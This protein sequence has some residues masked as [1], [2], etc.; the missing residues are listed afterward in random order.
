MEKMGPVTSTPCNVADV[1]MTVLHDQQARPS[2]RLCDLLQ[3]PTD[4]CCDRSLIIKRLLFAGFDQ[5]A[6]EQVQAMFQKAAQRLLDN[7]EG[8]EPECAVAAYWVP[9]RIEIAGKHTDYAGGRSLLAAVN[10]GFAVVAAQRDDNRVG[11]HAQF[12]DGRQDQRELKLTADLAQLRQFQSLPTNEGGWAAYPAAV[13]QRLVANFSICTG[14]HIS[15]ECNLPEASG[16]SSSS[17]VICYMWLV[18]DKYNGI[19]KGN[20]LFT[21][22]IRSSAELYTYLGNIENGKHFKP[23]DAAQLDGAG[24]VGTFGG[25]EDHTAIMSCSQGAVSLWKFCPT[26]H[27]AT[28][29]FDPAVSFCIAVSGAKAEKRGEAMVGYNDASLL[30]QWAAAAVTLARAASNGVALEQPLTHEVLARIYNRTSLYNP[31]LPNLAEVVRQERAELGEADASEVKASIRRR[32]DSIAGTFKQHFAVNAESLGLNLDGLDSERITMDLLRERFE[33]FFNESEVMLPEMVAA[34]VA[35]DYASFGRLA[36]R[37]HEATVLQLQNTVPETAWLARWARR[38]FIGGA[39][40]AAASAEPGPEA[41]AAS[42]FGAGFGGSCWAL[43]WSAEAEAF[44]HAWKVAYEAEFPERCGGLRRDF[45]VATPSPG[46]F[47][48]LEA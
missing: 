4:K 36:D 13:V 44:C 21:R 11:V 46:A 22:S 10:R 20:P 23:G 3:S 42:A 15:T 14:A 12:A 6:A 8:I 16:M 34:L 38:S 47:S 2:W 33:Q 40:M 43:V 45:F 17:A 19:S 24:G 39:A 30:A 27:L 32:L 29:T 28:L 31:S 18:L 41:L 1:G 25:S 9:G 48:L 37:S 5:A 35:R 26:E 7:V